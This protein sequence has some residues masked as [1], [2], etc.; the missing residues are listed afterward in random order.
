[1]AGGRDVDDRGECGRATRRAVLRAPP[2]ARLRLAGAGHGGPA[3][4]GRGERRALA[5]AGPHDARLRPGQHPPRAADHLGSQPRGRRPAQGGR[6]R[7]GR[8]AQAHPRHLRPLPG[9]HPPLPCR[10]RRGRDV[11][12]HGRRRVRDSAVKRQVVLDRHVPRCRACRQRPAAGDDDQPEPARLARS[13][14]AHGER[15]RPVAGRRGPGRPGGP[16]PRGSRR[17]GGERGGGLLAV[18]HHRAARQPRLVDPPLGHRD[19]R[20]VARRG[21]CLAPRRAAPPG[22]AGLAGDT[23][24]RGRG[25]DGCRPPPAPRPETAGSAAF[26]ARQRLRDHGP[27]NP[28]GRGLAISYEPGAR[29]AR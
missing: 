24:R 12:R 20:A 27:G 16:R 17:A 6:H 28:G 10:R 4:P 3:R 23:A 22:R 5:R 29:L 14:P 18:R 25:L 9:A 1:M 26:P 8:R 19:P 2:A 11:R 13:R 7:P 15:P 21:E